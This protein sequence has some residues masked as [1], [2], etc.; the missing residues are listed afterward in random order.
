MPP[1]LLRVPVP[2]LAH[3]VPKFIP[4]P[5]SLFLTLAILLLDG[6]S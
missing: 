4:F 1:F 6:Y 3:T 2:G 5:V